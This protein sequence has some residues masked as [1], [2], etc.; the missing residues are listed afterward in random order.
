[1]LVARSRESAL[2]EMSA[3]LR[4]AAKCCVSAAP[5]APPAMPTMALLMLPSDAS[6]MKQPGTMGEA[7]SRAMA[8]G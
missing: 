3:A 4:P 8:G 1:M 7:R 6:S 2:A 5:V